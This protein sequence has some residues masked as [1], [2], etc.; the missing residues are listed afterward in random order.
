M[1][2]A[3]VAAAN[4]RGGLGLRVAG[5]DVVVARAFAD[6]FLA[7]VAGLCDRRDARLLT[8]AICLHLDSGN[9]MAARQLLAEQR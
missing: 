8:T 7:P 2:S 9:G 3:S 4:D 1:I 6:R 5:G